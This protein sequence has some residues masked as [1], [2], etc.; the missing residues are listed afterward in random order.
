M[1]AHA[2]RVVVVA[3]A[4]KLERHAF[5]KICDLGDVDQLITDSAA[6]PNVVAELRAQG[7]AVD[8]D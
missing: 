4:S 8:L 3:D 7:V 6:D 2:R 5:C 1:V